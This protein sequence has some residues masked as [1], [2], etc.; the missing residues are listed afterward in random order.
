M[1]CRSL[2]N[3]KEDVLGL[4][5]RAHGASPKDGLAPWHFSFLF[6]PAAPSPVLRRSQM[7]N[8]CSLSSISLAEITTASTARL[9][10][11]RLLRIDPAPA[12]RLGHAL[13]HAFPLVPSPYDPA[14]DAHW[15][16]IISQKAYRTLVICA[17]QRADLGATLLS[18]RPTR[19]RR[20]FPEARCNTP[21][22]APERRLRSQ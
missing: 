5:D 12:P 11:G 6:P 8:M 2:D 18:P 22:S 7:G 4:G 15:T 14:W 17:L 16:A 20:L 21:G 10:D 19:P 13:L 1:L 9:Q 3:V